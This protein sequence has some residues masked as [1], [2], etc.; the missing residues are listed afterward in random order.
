[1]T[2]HGSCEG[3]P[4]A[5]YEGSQQHSISMA[6]GEEGT[7]PVAAVDMG[8]V[9][10][11]KTLQSRKD[12]RNRR[13]AGRRSLTRSSRKRGRYIQSRLSP[14]DYAD[15]AFDAT[16]RQA[17]PHQVQRMHDDVSFA[18]TADDLHRKVR[19]RR[20]AN[21]VLFVVDASW[22]M[23]A[24]ARMEATK[25]AVMSLLVD[26]YQ[27]RDRVGVVVF[28][29]E[30][31]WEALP[32][33]SSVELARRVLRKIPVGGKTPLPAGLFLA[34]KMI[35]RELN[36]NPELMPL[37]ILLTDGAAN[38][39]LAGRPAM[40]ESYALAELIRDKGVRS[41]V[42]NMEHVTFDRGLA[43]ELALRLD[44]VCYNLRDLKAQTL[45][46]TVQHEL[47]LQNVPGGG[48]RG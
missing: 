34:Y 28:Q 15:I 17:A 2:E 27:R 22:S 13:L 11:P 6:A 21:L 42:V 31:A 39:S 24:A 12:Q 16:F 9:F 35:K 29:K 36:L 8:E 7:V 18:V 32:F 4:V 3:E 41:V 44:G 40:E 19:V 37:M 14:G 20:A 10:R 45:Y 47:A 46:K 25:G 38:V 43:N 33:T 48:R 1:M 26:A 30:R 5:L 23:A